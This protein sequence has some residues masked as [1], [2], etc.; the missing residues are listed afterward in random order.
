MF[1]KYDQKIKKKLKK[2]KKKHTHTHTHTSTYTKSD[3][4]HALNYAIHT[5]YVSPQY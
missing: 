2:K 3:K 1:L 5:F 4:A